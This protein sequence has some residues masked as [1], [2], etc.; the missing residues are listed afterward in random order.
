MKSSN[1]KRLIVEIQSAPREK[2]ERGGTHRSP[3]KQDFF[4]RGGSRSAQESNL[5]DMMDVDDGEPPRRGQGVKTT[6]KRNRP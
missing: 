3:G 2:D 6:R 5:E 1:I 4:G